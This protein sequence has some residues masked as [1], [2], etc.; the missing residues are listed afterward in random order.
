[1]SRRIPSLVVSSLLVGATG[2]VGYGET[3]LAD[4]F[5]AADVNPFDVAL[6]ASSLEGVSGMALF[7]I[8]GMRAS[9]R[10]A[11]DAVSNPSDNRKWLLTFAGLVLANATIPLLV[12]IGMGFTDAN[13]GLPEGRHAHVIPALVFTLAQGAALAS[14]R[15]RTTPKQTQ[16]SSLG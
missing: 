1:M 14:L 2:L 3:V 15:A 13:G 7:N 6:P 9:K 12:D 5:A 10:Q 16:T 8:A 4:H 11:S